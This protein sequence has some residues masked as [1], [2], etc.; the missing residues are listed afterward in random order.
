MAIN[1]LKEHTSCIYYTHQVAFGFKI[2]EVEKSDK[3]HEVAEKANYILFVLEGCVR[4]RC[5]EFNMTVNAGNMV[6]IHRNCL[7]EY[8]NLDDSKYI[9]AYFESINQLCAKN[10]LASLVEYKRQTTYE[11]KPFPIRE[12]LQMYLT[13]LAHFLKDGANCKQLHDIKL[14]E[15]FWIF[16]AYYTKEELASFL[17][18]I[19]GAAHD[20]RYKVLDNYSHATTVQ[21]LAGMCGMSVVTFKRQFVEEFGEIPSTWLQKRLSSFIT[22]RLADRSV[23]LKQIIEE[24]HF[25][26]L[27]NFVRFCKKYLGETPGEIR[28]KMN[29][30]NIHLNL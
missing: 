17:Y 21:E 28:R 5:N 24:L 27:P 11:I 20:F 10:A 7:V 29:L 26:S 9:I 1:Y 2:F 22:F 3:P 16:R 19:I 4:L 25:S 6:F 30:E 8:K 18:T 12:E 23:P 13:P 15:L 14:Q